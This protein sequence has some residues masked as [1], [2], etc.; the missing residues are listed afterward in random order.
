VRARYWRDALKI[1]DEHPLLGVGADGYPIARTRIR[2]DTLFVQ[3]A[4]GY[5]VQVLADLGLVGLAISLLVCVLWVLAAIGTANP[6]GWRAPPGRRDHPPER[7]GLLTMIALVVL[8]AFHSLIDW[9]FYVPG[10][11]A[12]ALLCAGWVA[13]RGP[14]TQA[15]PQGAPRL[16]T[17]LRD[18]LRG[19]AA[20]A[21]VVLALAVAWSQWQPLR[22]SDAAAA[23]QIALG[24][25]DVAAARSDA[26]AAI[27]RDPLSAT[28]LFD[29]AAVD[30]AAGQLG[31]AQT[32]YDRAVRLEPANASAWESLAEFELQTMHNRSAALTDLG[33]ALYLD[34]GDFLAIEDYLS[35]LQS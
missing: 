11:A 9:T 18:P 13:G 7:V 1:F 3:D 27:D 30:I 15:P 32:E 14:W 16:R 25:H 2:Q 17:L 24:N 19:S 8:F 28:P 12:I 23:A 5:V 34:P 33:A 22:S 20:L 26:Q 31:A 35:A 29:M 4:H 6:F 10:D 21:T